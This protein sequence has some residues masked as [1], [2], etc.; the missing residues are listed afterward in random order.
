MSKK[1]TNKTKFDLNQFKYF[2]QPTDSNNEHF[3][4]NFLSEKAEGKHKLT[5]SCK[6][7]FDMDMKGPCPAKFSIFKNYLLI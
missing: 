6:G 2:L 4:E 3:T 7:L 5:Y 1:D